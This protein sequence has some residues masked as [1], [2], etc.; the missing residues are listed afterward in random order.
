MMS[1]RSPDELP[2]IPIAGRQVGDVS[3]MTADGIIHLPSCSV[4]RTQHLPEQKGECS[5]G[6]ALL[7][8]TQ[9]DPDIRS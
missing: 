7:T 1:H 9:S 8:P 6:A 3:L 5:C 4:W 2:N